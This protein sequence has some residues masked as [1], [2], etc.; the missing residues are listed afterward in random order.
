MEKVYN[1]NNRDGLDVSLKLIDNN[2]YELVV[3]AS[4]DPVF[5]VSPDDGEYFYIDPPGGP[6]I[7]RGSALLEYPNVT[8]EKIYHI[9]ERGAFICILKDDNKDDK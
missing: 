4:Y 5:N 9:K 1:L 3:N 7:V 2:E 8:V 6:M